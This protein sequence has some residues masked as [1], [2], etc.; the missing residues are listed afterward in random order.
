MVPAGLDPG[1]VIAQSLDDQWAGAELTRTMARQGS[2]FAD[3]ADPR[4]K[5]VRAEYIRALINTR[6]L[7]VNRVFFFNNPAVSRD[8]IA[9]GRARRAHQRLLADGALVPFLLREREPTDR[10]A[11]V[12][13]DETAFRAWQETVEELPATDRVTCVRLSWDDQENRQ[14]TD[15]ALFNPFAARVQGLTAKDIPL[16]AAQVG[17]AEEDTARFA[18]TIGEVVQ[19]SN[20]HRVRDERVT[21]TQ[22]YRAFV[23]ASGEPVSGGRLAQDKPFAAEVKQ[24]LDL[25]YNV[26]LADALGMYPLTPNGS[27]RRVALQEWRDLSGGSPAGTVTDAEQLMLFLRRQSFAAVQDRLTPGEVDALGLEDIWQL[28]QSESW[29]RYMGALSALTMDPRDFE[30]R[31]G[32]LF[33][34]YLEL[35]REIIRLAESRRGGRAR[36]RAWAPVIEVVVNVGGAVFTAVSGEESWSVVGSIG[37]AAVSSYGG[38]VQL[39]LRNRRS[40]RREQKFARELATVQL[41]SVREW[42]RL[43]TLVRAL[44]GYRER[45][46]AAPATSTSTVLDDIP[47]Y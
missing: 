42:Q 24:L 26:N 30:E 44:P 16:L 19:F 28:R 39:V 12:E 31:V 7:V 27:L 20:E 40:G 45:R 22:L 1:A 47:E 9:G 41:D 8:L 29:H 36:P 25:I 4:G 33:Q 3:V 18:E 23:T 38:S 2:S 35:N 21:R 15:S 13:V 5:E 43:H 17:V 11:N 34:R 37:S 32:P 46:G 10:P 14:A 6:Q